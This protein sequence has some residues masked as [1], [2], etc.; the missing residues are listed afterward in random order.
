MKMIRTA[1]IAAAAMV[2]FCMS[3]STAMA[4]DEPKNLGNAVRV[5]KEF[6]AAKKERIPPELLKDANGIVIIPGA[7]KNN[8]MVSGRSASGIL[9]VHETDGRWSDP[10]FITLSGGT[11]GWQMVGEPMDIILV[12]KNTKR[13]DDITKGNFTMDTRVAVVP[14]PLGQ[15]MKVA[16][17]VEKNAEIN[18]YVRSHGKFADVS[19]ASTTV[20]IDAASNDVFYGKQKINAGDILSGKVE[21][22]SDDVKKLQKFLAE[23]AASK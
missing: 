21:K 9:L 18:S 1:G 22:S 2:M 16:T 6:T 15:S 11:L 7:S 3:L 5:I 17:K 19:V 4:K 8:F 14:G 13:I 20:Q 23:Y 10:V 12:F